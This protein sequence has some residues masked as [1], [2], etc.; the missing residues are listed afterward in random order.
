MALLAVRH[1]CVQSAAVLPGD[2]GMGGGP[3]AV[4]LSHS[5]KA[6]AVTARLWRQQWGQQWRSA[7]K[8]QEQLWQHGSSYSSSS[9][10]CVHAG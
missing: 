4:K 2:S 7:G 6:V 1:G 8:G 10:M 3:A 9:C 5:T